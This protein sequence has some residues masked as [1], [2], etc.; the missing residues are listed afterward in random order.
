MIQFASTTGLVSFSKVSKHT[1][2]QPA[3][4]AI[5][6]S[7]NLYISER[8]GNKVRMITQG[9]GGAGGTITTVAGSGTQGDT[10]DGFAATSAQLNQP[11]AVAVDSS[12]SLYIADNG[13]R[14]VRLVTKATGFV[15]TLAGTGQSGEGV[16]VGPATLVPMC[17]TTGVAVDSLG[18]LYIADNSC[19]VVYVVVLSTGIMKTLPGTSGMNPYGVAVDALNQLYLTDKSNRKLQMFLVACP[20]GT[21]V[22]GE[23]CTVCSAGTYAATV[24]AASCLTCP[25]GSW[26]LTGSDKCSPC[27]P[28]TYSAS[29][30]ASSCTACAVGYGSD[31]GATVCVNLVAMQKQNYITT[32]LGTGSSGDGGDGGP[33][34]SAQSQSRGVAVDALGNLYFSDQNSKIRK[35][36][37]SSGIVT[38]IAG[39]GSGGD[40]VATSAKLNGPFGLAVD[41]SYVVYFAD[42]DDHKVRMITQGTGG[43]GGTLTTVAGMGDKGSTGDG[44]AATLAMLNSP[45]AV[46]VDSSGNVYIADQSNRKIRVVLKATGS[47]AWLI[48]TFAG[49]GSTQAD[50]VAATLAQLIY[51]T[52]VAVDSMGNVYI[53]DYTKVRMI[54]QGTGGAG[55]TITTLAGTGDKGNTGDG[56]AATLATLDQLQS[57]AIDSLGNLF[58]TEPNNN[59]KVRLI[60][61][62]T[63]IITTF[64]G[65]GCYGSSGDGWAATSAS[66]GFPGGVA[67][68]SSGNVFI[69]DMN[70]YRIRVVA[71]ACG[72]GTGGTGCALCDAGTYSTITAE[73][74]A[75]LT[76]PAGTWSLAGSTVC[77]PCAQ[78][79]NSA[80]AG[81][82]SANACFPCAPGQWSGVGSTACITLDR[83]QPVI[84]TVAGTGGTGSSGDGGP[85]PL[86]LLPVP[87]SFSLDSS[88]NMYIAGN[89]NFKIRFLSMT[90]GTITTFAGTGFSGGLGDGGAATLAQFGSLNGVAV[91]VSALSG[92][93]NVYITDG[94]N[95]RVRVVAKS[96]GI[97]TTFAGGGS[98]DADGGVAPTAI[99]MY[100]P[101]G[102]AVDISGNVYIADAGCNKVW[103]VTKSTSIITTIVGTAGGAL[104]RPFGVAVDISGNVFVTDVGNANVRMITPA[105]VITTLAG[106]GSSNGDGAAATLAQLV[107]PLGV[108]VDMSGNVYIADGAAS[109]IRFVE[110]STGIIT[111]IAGTGVAAFGG[112]GG[113]AT[114]AQLN[115][116]YSAILAASGAVYIAD[117]QNSRIRVITPP[118]PVG[119]TASALTCSAVAPTA[120]TAVP[121]NTPYPTI[122][123]TSA[124]TS[125]A[126][127]PSSQPSSQPS[128]PPSSQPSRQPIDHPTS[129]P[130]VQ[131]TTKPSMQ[132]STLPT[133]QP[134]HQ[135]TTQPSRPTLSPTPAPTAAPSISP[136]ARPTLT[137]F[138]TTSP[139]VRLTAAAGAPSSAPTVAQKVELKVTQ[140][141]TGVTPDVAKTPSFQVLFVAA[142][143]ASLGLDTATSKVTINSVS[144][145]RQLLADSVSIDYTV[146][147]VNISPATLAL[148]VTTA[149]SATG[150]ASLAT[151]LAVAG[152]AGVTAETPTVVD[153]SP[154]TAGGAPTPTPSKAPFKSAGTTLR[155]TLALTFTLTLV[156][157]LLSTALA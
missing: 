94:R 47:A 106:G 111:T 79:T 50:G 143:L 11:H 91:D 77:T 123:P 95:C 61:K 122:S 63:G 120:P 71:L 5:D 139:S 138:P 144:R 54:T 83:Q 29:T 154:V 149:A 36:T 128:V 142:V 72:P 78:N 2:K 23:S 75:C 16:S 129:Q 118:C 134:S 17:S 110:K 103:K 86:A 93:G 87:I 130:S 150:S 62:S 41:S 73:A 88:G 116:P 55:G 28:G 45:C 7:N 125:G 147:T 66:F 40:G 30:G 42:R 58:V 43:A 20:A 1:P 82:T 92:T 127:R 33:A 19:S 6:A 112:D 44:F 15:T 31:P 8:G 124:P 84:T 46:A 56:F 65:S 38:T 107:F 97:I 153:I 105:G 34:T 99:Q 32:Y 3:G 100:L 27:A 89:G 102:V 115:F 104:F 22:S 140:K 136:T 157:A 64:A 146:S 119:S 4:I 101:F 113:P 39:G 133:N 80:S 90:T 74:G 48:A 57:I 121:L 49:G 141:L 24:N 131:P 81:A 137:A 155:S 18:T 148:A 145:R 108:S 14:K 151:Q 21:V 13:N 37:K 12:F 9:T 67:V 156:A 26:S 10:G 68:D 96:T 85:A 60:T 109:R 52:G 114:L 152:V 76:C 135:P 98:S 126:K 51:P 132:P 69:S 117:T 70:T 35:V 59:F 53:A 25:A